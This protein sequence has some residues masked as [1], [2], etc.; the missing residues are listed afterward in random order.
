M[1]NIGT[2]CADQE[3]AKCGQM[4][5]IGFCEKRKDIMKDTCPA[6]CGLCRK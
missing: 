6:T 3:K 1:H 2:N 4:K 5:K